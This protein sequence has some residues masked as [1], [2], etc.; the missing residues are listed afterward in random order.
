MSAEA[1]DFGITPE[2][3][4]FVK[5]EEGLILHPYRDPVGLP[6]IGYGHRIDSMDRP[7]L[8]PAGAEAL[9]L[10]DLK[11]KRDAL[12]GISPSLKVATP[13]RVAALIDFCFNL[14]EGAYQRSLLRKCVDGA[15]WALAAVQMRRWVYAG[16]KVF[17][18]LVERRAVTARWLAEG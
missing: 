7:P 11:G 2:L 15:E 9:L 18:P 10:A 12:L 5:K 17:Q 14:G 8:T 6:T 3:L 4:A 16:G 13:R 1:A